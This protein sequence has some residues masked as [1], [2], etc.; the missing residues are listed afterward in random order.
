VKFENDAASDIP[1]AAVVR[2]VG[3][4]TGARSIVRSLRDGSWITRSR[5]SIYPKLVIAVY[6]LATF[7][8]LLSYS[9]AGTKHLQLGVDFAPFYAASSLALSGHPAQVYDDASLRAAEHRVAGYQGTTYESWDYPPTFLL[10]VLPSS[11][12]SYNLSLM[13]WILLTLMAYL[14][15]IWAIL[16]NRS[17]M[18]LSV[19]F[20][21]AFVNMRDGQNG[22]V[23]LAN[24]RG[25]ASIG[26]Q[27]GAGGTAIRTSK[28]QASIR[29]TDTS[30]PDR[31]GTSAR[32]RF[33]RG[34][35]PRNRR[36][37][38]MRV[39]YRHLE[40]I[41]RQ[42]ADHE[43][44]AAGNWVDRLRENAKCIW[45]GALVGCV[46]GDLLCAPGPSW[47]RDSG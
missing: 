27:A 29:N 38:R 36:A 42:H 28:L 1:V 41:F 45:H 7:F 14:S 2:E 5:L 20:P 23:S 35:D 8:F 9:G 25:T 32:F 34:Y 37:D 21:A 26:A 30:H 24:G 3:S 31:D 10:M 19:A 47:P 15:V 13:T 33:G 46:G 16:P 18:W 39:R 43:S 22:F 40:S 4:P 44:S 17:A 11:L 12:L 6:L